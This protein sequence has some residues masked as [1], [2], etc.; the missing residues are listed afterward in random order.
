MIGVVTIC[1]ETPDATEYRSATRAKYTPT[2]TLSDEHALR[3]YAQIN[4]QASQIPPSPP[5]SISL[6]IPSPSFTAPDPRALSL[7]LTIYLSISLSLSLSL[8]PVP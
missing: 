1:L 4:H 7:F 6:S 2:Y 5:T 8:S 3:N